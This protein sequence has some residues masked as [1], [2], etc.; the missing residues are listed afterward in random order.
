MIQCRGQSS[1]VQLFAGHDYMT[2][3][4]EAPRVSGACGCTIYKVLD[5]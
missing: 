1:R 4:H 5:G 3:S 2:A